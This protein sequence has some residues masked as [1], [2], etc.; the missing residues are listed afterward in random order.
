[1]LGNTL[2]FE[3]NYTPSEVFGHPF[4]ATPFS[5]AVPI[6]GLPRLRI[7]G[8]NIPPYVAITVGGSPVDTINVDVAGS[9]VDV[10]IPKGR[11]ISSITL[12]SGP[13]S[14]EIPKAIIYRQTSSNRMLR[15]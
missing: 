9:W 10:P 2:F 5:K 7:T 4:K 12:S 1:M 6:R 3:A 14:I 13:E 11:G 15:R 8:T